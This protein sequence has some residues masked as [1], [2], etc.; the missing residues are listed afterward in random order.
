[1]LTYHPPLFHLSDAL[2]AVAAA[3]VFIA[4]ASLLREPARQR[5]MA[6]L[7]A[8]AGSTYIS[9]G[10]GPWEYAFST[11]MLYVAYRGLT[12]YAFIGLAAAHGLGR[13]APFLRQPHHLAGAHFIGAVRH[14]RRADCRVVFLPRPVCVRLLP[15]RTPSGPGA[16]PVRL[17]PMYQTLLILHSLGRWAVVLGL[18][19]GL[20]RAYRGW[21]GRRPFPAFDNA[22]RHSVATIAHVQLVLG[23]AL[24]F[25]SPLIASFHLRDA[26]HASST[27]FFG[28]QHVAVM[29]TAIVVLT[30]G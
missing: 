23:Y 24:Y 1:M 15:S 21:L 5:F 11:L 20:F 28:V 25:V 3:G 16:H 19:L 8:G 26:E 27:L 2:A 22:V 7:I 6:L 17:S 4:L 10:L 18:L 14:L 13:A 29:T 9:G 30:L 12:H